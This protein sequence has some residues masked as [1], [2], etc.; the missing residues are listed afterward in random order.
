MSS[1]DNQ[2]I[3]C[4]SMRG[5]RSSN[6]LIS[7]NMLCKVR[8]V[9]TGVAANGLYLS[10]AKMLTGSRAVCDSGISD[11]INAGDCMFGI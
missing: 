1:D 2:D 8:H 6:A 7:A 5:L 4:L 10:R 11:E 3:M 9:S